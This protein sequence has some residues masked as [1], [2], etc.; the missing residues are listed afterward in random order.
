[1]PEIKLVIKGRIPSKKNHH[2]G[3]CI[4]NPKTGKYRAI[5]FLDNKY[6]NWEKEQILYLSSVKKEENIE[7]ISRCSIS[8]KFYFPDKRKTD[9]HNKAEGVYDAL[10]SSNILEDDNS[11]VIPE[12]HLLFGGV[13]KD[14]PRVEIDLNEL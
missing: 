3:L 13:D 5:V 9:L 12:Q 4:R 7:T 10:V 11:D 8:M 1:M 2:S 14:D 6:K